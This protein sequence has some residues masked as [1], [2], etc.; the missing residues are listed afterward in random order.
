VRFVRG[1]ITL[2]GLLMLWQAVVWMAAP[3]PFILPGPVQ[4][5]LTLV[6]NAGSLAENAAITAI[7]MLVGLALGTLLGIAIALL[8]AGSTTVQRWGLPVL[9]LS[10][11]LPVFALAPVL[12]LW[13]GFGLASKIAMTTLITLFPVALAYLEGMRRTDQALIDL[14]RLWGLS[15]YREVLE[16]RAKAALPALASGFKG[17][18][19]AS[20][21]AAI[22]GEWV[23]AAGGLGFVMIQANA[24]MQTDMLF[25]AVVVLMAM[26]V[27]LWFAVEWA[28]SR[29]LPWAADSARQGDE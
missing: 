16:I 6:W 7:E 25:A 3:P 9:I 27:A 22:I 1:L 10:Q 4:V 14:G 19:A 21:M 18:A 5:L 11:A 17:A 12:V 13:L 15:G 20:P 2:F 24:R 8:L 29:A 26:G 23:G 28:L